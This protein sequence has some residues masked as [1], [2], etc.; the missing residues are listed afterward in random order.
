MNKLK[1][2][3]SGFSA[4]EVILVVIII[5]LLGTVGWLV[6]KNHNKKTNAA[7]VNKN[8]NNKNTF[9]SNTPS[10]VNPYAGWKS[11]TLMNEKITFQYPSDWTLFDNSNSTNASGSQQ[12]TDS[13]SLNAPGASKVSS[14]LSIEDGVNGNDVP[15][16]N[17]IYTNPVDVKFADKDNYLVF[18]GT[19]HP[20]QDLNGIGCSVLVSSLPTTSS[21]AA[22][23]PLAKN[24]LDNNGNNN[25]YIVACES[26]GKTF[27]KSTIDQ[28]INDPVFNTNKL[29]I[30]SM[31]Y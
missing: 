15:L 5:G 9:S 14:T 21:S 18:A 26:P 24:V 1:N 4:L 6:Y 30:E 16:S 10:T 29:I 22:N 27:T 20:G 11:Y 2:N 7:V 12:N 3:H 13:V 17:L 28:A 19:A 8:I 23:L 25:I 31:H